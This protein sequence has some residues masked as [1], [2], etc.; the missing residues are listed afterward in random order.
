MST[1]IGAESALSDEILQAARAIVEQ[2]TAQGHVFAYG[3]GWANCGIKNPPLLTLLDQLVGACEP[4]ANAI[5]DK[6]RKSTR[7]NSSHVSESRMP[8]SA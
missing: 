7:L 3:Y 4:V 2:R 1:T 8:S 5:A 6:D